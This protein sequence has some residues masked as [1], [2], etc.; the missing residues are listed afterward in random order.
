M[1]VHVLS[2]V[3]AHTSII[4]DIIPEN[5][6]IPLNIFF[7]YKNRPSNNDYDFM[8]SLPRYHVNE[9]DSITSPGPYTVIIPS[10]YIN[11]TGR[12]FIGVKP[13]VNVT[14]VTVNY[15]FDPFV[16]GCYYWH[17]QRAIWTTDGCKVRL[18][19]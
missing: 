18:S 7:K 13:N 14:D 12:Y 5:R 11:V 10:D 3:R 2:K 4:I 16:T 19:I 15:T 1:T 17:E 9:M 6:S 8:T